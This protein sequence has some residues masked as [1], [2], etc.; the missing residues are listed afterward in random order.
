MTA[1]LQ[2]LN[3][4]IEHLK[5]FRHSPLLPAMAS[6]TI[7]ECDGVSYRHSYRTINMIMSRLKS[8]FPPA[9]VLLLTN[10]V[11][12]AVPTTRLVKR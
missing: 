4:A 7:A 11:Y 3:P 9:N 8:K 2:S 10:R 12:D 5:T 6:H 1:I